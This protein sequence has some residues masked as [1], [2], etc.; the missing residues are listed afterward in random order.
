MAAARFDGD[1]ALLSARNLRTAPLV[2]FTL[3]RMGDTPGISTDVKKEIWLESERWRRWSSHL[4]R[5]GEEVIGAIR[6][7]GFRV[8]PIK[9]F[10]FAR[11]LYPNA[12][13]RPMMDIDLLLPDEDLAPACVALKED[14]GFAEEEGTRSLLHARHYRKRVLALRTEGGN[15]CVDMHSVFYH[16]WLYPIDYAA[17]WDRSGAQ[18]PVL[19]P[20]DSLLHS[21]LI[22]AKDRY[23]TDLRDLVDIHEILMQ[24]KPDWPIVLER[25]R[26]WGC[27]VALFFSLSAAKGILES[28]VPDWVLEKCRPG[29]VRRSWLEVFLSAE[30]VPPYRYN[31]GDV[32]AKAFL[33]LP[34]ADSIRGG[35]RFLVEHAVFRWGA[36]RGGRK[37]APDG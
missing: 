9:G 24:W 2:D 6:T 31:H 3:T 5:G 10:D 11:R 1:A 36:P 20:E 26:E 12:G 27:S 18:D 8:I 29:R 4:V 34:L 25:A 33:R 7:R 22:L 23:Q 16:P 21:C 19:S 14:L 32:L 37:A 30:R 28:P 35:L 15:L 17:I 13:L